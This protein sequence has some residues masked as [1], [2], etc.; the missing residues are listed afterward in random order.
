MQSIN[1]Y[2]FKK[3]LS[4]DLNLIKQ[5][6]WSAYDIIKENYIDKN[7]KHNRQLSLG[8]VSYK[9]NLFRLGYPGFSLLH[10]QIRDM[11]FEI[12]PNSREQ[13]YIHCWLNLCDQ[14]GNFPWHNHSYRFAMLLG[15]H[16]FF[17]VDVEPSSTYYKFLDTED[18]YELEDKDNLLI[19]AKNDNDE[20]RTYPWPYN[21]TRITIPFN[22]VS[23]KYTGVLP[24]TASWFPL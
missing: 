21:R 22:I 6:C 2:I 17:C 16:G 19:M 18:I 3:Q 23:S 11:F 4:L 24:C 1:N 5:E 15:M 13:H 8:Y 12:N 20:H 10:E 9:Y 14:N 7:S